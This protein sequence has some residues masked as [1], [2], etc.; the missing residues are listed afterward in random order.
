MRRRLPKSKRRWRGARPRQYYAK[1]R[2]MRLVGDFTVNPD[3]MPFA[4]SAP[5][6]LMTTMGTS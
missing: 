4:D 1:R 3:A 6:L 5:L 2:T